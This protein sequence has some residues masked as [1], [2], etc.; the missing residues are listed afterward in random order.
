MKKKI[1]KKENLK[2]EEKTELKT[3]SFVYNFIDMN[4][5]DNRSICLDQL[6]IG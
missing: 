3:K 4:S 1:I 2:N 6:S 5:V